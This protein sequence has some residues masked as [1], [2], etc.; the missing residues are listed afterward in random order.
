[1]ENVDKTGTRFTSKAKR[2]LCY[3][4]MVPRPAG[5]TLVDEDENIEVM[6]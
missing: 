1:M 4:T 2:S 6:L 5:Y 3:P